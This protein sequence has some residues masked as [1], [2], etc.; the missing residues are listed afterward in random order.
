MNNPELQQFTLR[1]FNFQHI[2]KLRPNFSFNTV[3]NVQ[4]AGQ[5]FAAFVPARIFAIAVQVDI[6]FL[7]TQVRKVVRCLRRFISAKIETFSREYLRL[8]VFDTV[9]QFKLIRF[10]LLSFFEGGKNVLF[11][12]PFLAFKRN[13][14]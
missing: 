8:L 3:G 14:F 11:L 13:S 6:K 9:F 12:T 4:N 2:A 7:F 1:F 5:R 10:H